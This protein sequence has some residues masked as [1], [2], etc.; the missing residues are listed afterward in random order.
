M[1]AIVFNPI[2]AGGRAAETL[3]RVRAHLDGLG[4]AY[5]VKTSQYH[6][7]TIELV[8]EAAAEGA[9]TIL[10]IGGDGTVMEAVNGLAGMEDAPPLGFLPGGTGNDFTRSLGLDR[11]PVTALSQL[12]DGRTVESDLWQANGRYFINLIGLGLDTDLVGWSLRTKKI[13]RGISA[14]IAALMLT[15]VTFRFKKVRLTVDGETLEREVIVVTCTNGQYYGGGM[16]VSPRAD[17]A[18]GKL[19]IVIVNKIA[20][21]RIPFVLAKYIKGDHIHEPYCE[22]LQGTDITIE[23]LNGTLL[24]ETDGEVDNRP[25]VVIG[26]AGRIRVLAPSQYQNNRKPAVTE[27]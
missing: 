1:I 26:P 18:D 7:H 3:E 10:T 19:D 14:Y 13:L 20:K 22:Y 11:D 5:A 15:L 9:G 2:A 8:R 4:L 27:P 25:P 17:I 16:F 24:Y 21:L 23:T 6:R 12:L